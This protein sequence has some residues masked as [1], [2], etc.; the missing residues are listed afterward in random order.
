MRTILLIALTFSTVLCVYSQ[1]DTI[2]VRIIYGSKPLVK[3]ESKWFGGKLGGHVGLQTGK[4]SVFHFN[5]GAHVNATK[6]NSSLGR[7]VLSYEKQFW[8]TFGNDSMKTIS[9]YIPIDTDER[10]KIVKQA[11]LF[12][13][14]SP[15]KYAF[16]GMRCTAACYHLLSIGKLYPELS[17]RK[18]TN[19]FFYPRKLRKFLLAEAK[20][21]Q[22]KVERTA[23]ATNRKWD[24]D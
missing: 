7:Y 21:N 23:G 17:E 8:Y 13:D 3:S 16:F 6:A 1:K 5:P 18:M 14:N 15:Y 24:H 22:W 19:R 11:I 12:Q 9:F 20:K 4:D 2:V 10:S